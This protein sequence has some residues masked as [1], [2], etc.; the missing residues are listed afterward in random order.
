MHKMLKNNNNTSTNNFILVVYCLLAVL[1]S[2]LQLY[3][4]S[5]NST[6]PNKSM[7]MWQSVWRGDKHMAGR[8]L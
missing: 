1:F 6:A 3:L 5:T 7:A 8:F 2:T 4:E